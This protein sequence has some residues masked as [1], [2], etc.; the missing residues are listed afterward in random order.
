MTNS[1]ANENYNEDLQGEIW[2][3]VTN[4]EGIYEVSNY[5]RIKSL[6]NNISRKEK[7][8]R[9]QIRNG[10][11]SV[12]LSKK[13]QK[14]KKFFVHRLVAIAFIPNPLGKKTVNHEDGNKLCNRL[15]NLSWMT[16]SENIA[17]A[18]AHGLMKKGNKPIVAT[19]I[20]T[21]EQLQFESHSEASR[22]LGVSMHNINNVIQGKVLHIN[23]WKFERSQT[24]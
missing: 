2:L 24:A 5:G 13:G 8:L 1:K 10:Y 20:E 21:G 9:Q 11:M 17:H 16:H 15:E 4:Y 3:P 18:I 14:A 22:E 7:I 19:H 12:E 23:R 6:S